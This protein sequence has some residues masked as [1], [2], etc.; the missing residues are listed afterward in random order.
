[1]RAA[2]ILSILVGAYFVVMAFAAPT[3]LRWQTEYTLGK[4]GAAEYVD[5]AVSV[6]LER[7]QLDFLITKVLASG[8]IIAGVLML[9]RRKAGLYLDLGVLL[10]AACYAGYGF[11]FVDT[12]ILPAIKTLGWLYVIYFVFKAHRQHGVAWWRMAR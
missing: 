12:G 6:N 4:Y 7:L 8:L 5:L 11:V 9:L 3:I 10:A 1:M 2:S